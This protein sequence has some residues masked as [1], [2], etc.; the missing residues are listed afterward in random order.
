[1]NLGMLDPMKIVDDLI[2]AL[3][4]GAGVRFRWTAGGAWYGARVEM[5]LRRY[6]IRVYGR[7]YAS[8]DDPHLSVTVRRQQAQWAAYVLRQAGVPVVSPAWATQPA[9]HGRMPRAWG[10]PARAT[11]FGGVAVQMLFGGPERTR[12]PRRKG[13]V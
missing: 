9:R 1:M 2:C 11:G 5:L 10:V 4:F 8:K 7:Q 12:A 13:K 3:R 6:G